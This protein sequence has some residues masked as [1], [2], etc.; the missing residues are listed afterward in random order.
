[1]HMTVVRLK[2]L[3][4]RSF[5]LSLRSC[6][7]EVLLHLPTGDCLSIRHGADY[8]AQLWTYFVQYHRYLPLKLEI[9][10]AGDH[11]TIVNY[12]SGDC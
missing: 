3:D 10:D 7:G 6:K 5:L 8:E 4:L 12:Y 11:M 9:A 1:M 2:I